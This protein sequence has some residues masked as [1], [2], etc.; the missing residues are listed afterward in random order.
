MDRARRFRFGGCVNG[1]GKIKT[2]R[3]GAR[4]RPNVRQR[5]AANPD[6][7]IWVAASAGSGKTKALTDRVLRLLLPREDGR[8]GS[9]PDKILCITF[10]KAGAGEMQLRLSKRWPRGPLSPMKSLRKNLK[11]C[12]VAMRKER[13][14]GGA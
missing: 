5:I 1:P 10:T 7:S 8:D 12:S 2:I 13:N 6:S 9:P 14:R 3:N 11:T 4:H